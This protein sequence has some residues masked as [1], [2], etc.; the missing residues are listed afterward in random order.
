MDD[1]GG[2]I[3]QL[4]KNPEQM[5]NLMEAA[6]TLLPQGLSGEESVMDQERINEIGKLFQNKDAAEQKQEALMQALRPYL[7]PGRRSKLDRAMQM[8]KLSHIAG[9]AL[10]KDLIP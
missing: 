6:K 4:L 10:K 5:Q 1:L 3:S 8:A 9:I 2:I 7:R